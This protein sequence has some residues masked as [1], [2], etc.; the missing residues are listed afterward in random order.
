MFNDSV[1]HLI[2]N[3]KAQIDEVVG[4]NGVEQSDATAD[5]ANRQRTRRAN[6]ASRR[7]LAAQRRALRLRK[8][9]VGAA[10]IQTSLVVKLATE[11]KRLRRKKSANAAARP[12]NADEPSAGIETLKLSKDEFIQFVRQSEKNADGYVCFVGFYARSAHIISHR[13]SAV[14]LCGR[15]QTHQ[16][17][18]N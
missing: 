7:A 9:D 1:V 11:Q 17:Q 14:D 15:S 5:E 13:L 3:R 8:I 6:A 18:F 4:R 10:R 2:V 12:P 16:F